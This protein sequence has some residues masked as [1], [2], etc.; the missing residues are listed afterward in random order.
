MYLKCI[1]LFVFILKV[2]SDENV[3]DV[4]ISKF[5]SFLDL[6]I[7]N[8]HDGYDLIESEVLLKSSD[9]ENIANSLEELQLKVEMLTNQKNSINEELKSLRI[10]FSSS[11]KDLKS[12]SDENS[13]LKLTNI[14]LEVAIEKIKSEYEETLLKLSSTLDVV[15]KLETNLVQSKESF[16]VCN[17]KMKQVQ[18]IEIKNKECLQSESDESKQCRI[19]LAS[20]LDDKQNLSNEIISLNHKLEEESDEFKLLKRNVTLS[21]AKSKIFK[22]QELLVRVS[23]DTCLLEKEVLTQECDLKIYNLEKNICINN[24]DLGSNESIMKSNEC[25]INMCYNLAT[26]QAKDMFNHSSYIVKDTIEEAQNLYIIHLFPFMKTILNQTTKL[27]NSSWNVVLPTLI[28]FYQQ[29]IFP[30][31]SNNIVP[32]LLP[33]AIIIHNYYV[34]YLQTSVEDYLEPPIDYLFRQFHFIA[35][36]SYKYIESNTTPEGFSQIWIDLISIFSNIHIVLFNSSFHK[37]LTIYLGDFTD[38]ILV[39]SLIFI[40]IS[41]FYKLKKYIFAIGAGILMILFSPVLLFVFIFIELPKWF[42]YGKA[43]KK[44]RKNIEKGQTKN[45]IST[46]TD[47]ITTMSTTK[48]VLS[49]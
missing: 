33:Y 14:N 30:T 31:Y 3:I 46:E 35:Y 24:L 37:L 26:F 1:F 48:V 7:E 4:S 40:G 29:Y 25:D 2:Y 38:I 27:L 36:Y 19:L 43:N 9:K 6:E 49:P 12:I 23:Y 17:E 47:Q 34:E 8:I 13:D 10:L 39:L 20:T 41:I 32:V 42:I 18:D 45:N 28:S 16:S 21:E 15:D 5:P 22:N 11:V 44:R